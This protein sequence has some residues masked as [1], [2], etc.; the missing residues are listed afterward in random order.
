MGK[1]SREDAKIGIGILGFQKW[2]ALKKIK[3]I[4][5]QFCFGYK[6]FHFLHHVNA[7]T[8]KR[9]SFMKACGFNFHYPGNSIGCFASGLFCYECHRHL[10][11]VSKQTSNL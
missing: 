6:F 10:R 8:I 4:F 7:S 2:A 11:L 5:A 3:L 9:Y 1:T